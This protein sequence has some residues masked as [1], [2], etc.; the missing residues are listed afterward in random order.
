MTDEKK[1]TVFVDHGDDGSRPHTLST[2]C[3]CQP[4][5]EKVEPAQKK[6]K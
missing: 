5:V 3:W 2:D 1:E 4:R 6:R